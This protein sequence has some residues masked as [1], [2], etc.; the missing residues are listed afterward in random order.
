[1]LY[2]LENEQFKVL[3]QPSDMS[4]IGLSDDVLA[5]LGEANRW[6]TSQDIYNELDPKPNRRTLQDV[7]KSLAESRQVERV[8]PLSAG[9][10]QGVTA[11]WHLP[12]EGQAK[13]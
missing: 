13:L 2:T 9:T 7:L 6:M 8:P 5:I 4:V 11:F 10:V 12:G 3:G 1:M